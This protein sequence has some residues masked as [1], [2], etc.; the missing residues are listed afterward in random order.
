MARGEG[1]AD[2]G[3][4]FTDPAA[5]FEQAQPERVELE[6][7]VPGGDEPAALEREEARCGAR[8]PGQDGIASRSARRQTGG[9]GMDEPSTRGAP[10]NRG[11]RSP[12]HPSGAV[13]VSRLRSGVA[14]RGSAMTGFGF[15]NY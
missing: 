7:F 2:T 5:D 13:Y 10:P 12:G 15:C 4:Q 9:S 6:A 1:E 11:A 8:A 3:E 14:G